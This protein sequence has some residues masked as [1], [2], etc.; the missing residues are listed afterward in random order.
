[1]YVSEC[2]Y[3]K[4]LVV[5]TQTIALMSPPASGVSSPPLG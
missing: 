3:M 2:M 1:M 4:M 5:M